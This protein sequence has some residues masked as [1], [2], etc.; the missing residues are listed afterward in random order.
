MKRVLT[1]TNQVGNQATKICVF[2]VL[3]FGLIT[4]VSAI[5]LDVIET[6]EEKKQQKTRKRH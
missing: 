3:I 1:A 6:R 5:G 4:F 2:G